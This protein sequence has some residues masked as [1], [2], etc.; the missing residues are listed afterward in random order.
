MNKLKT[1][2]IKIHPTRFQPIIV[3]FGENY[4]TYKWDKNDVDVIKEQKEWALQHLNEEVKFH[5]VDNDWGKIKITK[6]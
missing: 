3:Y 4:P 1:G 5:I 2:T 6:K